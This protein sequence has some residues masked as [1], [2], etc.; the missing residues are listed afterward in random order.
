MLVYDKTCKNEF[1]PALMA[2]LP[3]MQRILKENSESGEIPDVRKCY[4]SI[5]A[6]DEPKH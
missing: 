2:K 5:T 3:S 4:R 1:G 6:G